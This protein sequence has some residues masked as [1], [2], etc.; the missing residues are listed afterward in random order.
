MFKR[1]KSQFFLRLNFV[2]SNFQLCTLCFVFG[3]NFFELTYIQSIRSLMILIYNELYYDHSTSSCVTMLHNRNWRIISF[4]NSRRNL[5]QWCPWGSISSNQSKGE[6]YWND[7][8]V[9]LEP[10]CNVARILPHQKHEK[11]I[12]PIST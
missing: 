9:I 8:I 10:M 2:L 5:G 7:R 1:R 12:S 6:I 4:N 11:S 3:W